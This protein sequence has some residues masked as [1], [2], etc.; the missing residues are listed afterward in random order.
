MPDVLM[1]YLNER[2]GQGAELSGEYM[3]LAN[4]AALAALTDYYQN[5]S[6]EY[7]GKDADLLAKQVERLQAA[8]Q[9][10]ADKTFDFCV[11]Y[12]MQNL[13]LI[14]QLYLCCAA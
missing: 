2:R 3:T 12:L 11:L 9:K 4:S 7:S 14:V 8:M 5:Q 13:L 1:S 6:A 10:N